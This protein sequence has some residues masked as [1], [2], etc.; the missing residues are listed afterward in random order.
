MSGTELL[1][2]GLYILSDVEPTRGR[3]ERGMTLA[4][5]IPVVQC[6]CEKRIAASQ[7]YPRTSIVRI[8]LITAPLTRV[9]MDRQQTPRAQDFNNCKWWCDK[10]GNSFLSFPSFLFSLFPLPPSLSFS[11]TFLVHFSFLSLKRHLLTFFFFCSYQHVLYSKFPMFYINA[12]YK[13][14]G[15]ITP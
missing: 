15:I 5:S 2:T 6:S 9:A 14:T 11:L 1:P 10:I 7:S 8:V 12:L 13:F 4:K 3:G